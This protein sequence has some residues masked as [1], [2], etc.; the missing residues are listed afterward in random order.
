[1]VP[2]DNTETWEYY[3]YPENRYKFFNP[4]SL[5]ADKKH[6]TFNL[7]PCPLLPCVLV[8]WFLDRDI[9]L[10]DLRENIMEIRGQYLREEDKKLLQPL[11]NLCRCAVL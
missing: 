3:E 10:A 8:S 6:E 1:M 5:T 4:G 9:T 7:V 11:L 2:K